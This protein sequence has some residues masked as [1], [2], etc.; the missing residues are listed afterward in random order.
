MP[1]LPME[2]F[3]RSRSM[4]EDDE[5]PDE[6]APDS[7][8]ALYFAHRASEEADAML[9]DQCPPQ[10]AEVAPGIFL[11]GLR[12]AQSREALQSRGVDCVLCMAPDSCGTS[13]VRDFPKCFRTLDIDA[14]DALHYDIFKEDVPKALE[15]V[16]QCRTNGGRVLVH[17]FAGMNRSAT[18]CAAWILKQQRL[19]LGKVVKH[20][21]K[22]RGLVLQNPRFLKG[23]VAMARDEGL[24]HN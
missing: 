22:H 3:D 18:I 9:D 21:A 11:G 19:P 8:W 13:R 23:L 1:L 15:F 2:C 7:D 4:R 5:T 24:L 6:A 20:L 17:C 12:E 16:E 10:P 14:I